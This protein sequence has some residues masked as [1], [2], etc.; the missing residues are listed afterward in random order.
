MN[1]EALLSTNS[2]RRVCTLSLAFSVAMLAT[3]AVALPEP[4]VTITYSLETADGGGYFQ[5]I[6]GTPEQ[7]GDVDFVFDVVDSGDPKVNV[8][9]ASPMYVTMEFTAD[10]PGGNIV[11]GPVELIDAYFEREWTIDSGFTLVHTDIDV[12]LSRKGTGTLSGST[13][14][15]DNVVA[16]YQESADGVANCTGFGCLFAS[17]PFPRDLS[18]T[19][20]DVPLP[21]FSVLTDAIFGDSFA[22][23]NGTPGDPS[24]DIDRP[25]AQATVKDTWVG[26]EVPEPSREAL[27]LAGILGLAGLGRLRDRRGRRRQDPG[28][29]VR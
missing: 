28:G 24:D 21:T 23:D 4:K 26:V 16:P 3:G 27:L 20:N 9:V 13:I 12:W 7:I 11:D 18:V 2:L 8:L 5:K 6:S 15:W 22:S 14:T 1:S 29:T 25:D 10:A 17:P 19:D